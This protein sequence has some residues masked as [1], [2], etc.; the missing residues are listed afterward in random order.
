MV[1]TCEGHILQVVLLL[2]KFNSP[3]RIQNEPVADIYCT[4]WVVAVS[5]AGRLVSKLSAVK[6]DARV[7]FNSLALTQAKGS[8]KQA[9]CCVP[10][11]MED[12]LFKAAPLLLPLPP[13]P[14]HSESNQR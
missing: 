6:K 12:Y 14:Q 7:A 1:I 4:R 11:E 3:F 13:L 5:Q 8:F 2:S 9:S 10:A